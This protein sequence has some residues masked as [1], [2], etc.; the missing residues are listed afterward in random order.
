ML[1]KDAP[2]LIH[3]HSSASS[4]LISRDDGLQRSLIN[5][6]HMVDNGHWLQCYKLNPDIF[7]GQLDKFIS[8]L[9]VESHR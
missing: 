7:M 2:Y 4:N 3:T 8:E 1:T 5:R 9:S 6:A